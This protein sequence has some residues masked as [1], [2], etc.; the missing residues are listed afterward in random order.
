MPRNRSSVL[1]LRV[2]LFSNEVNE[3]PLAGWPSLKLD[4][5]FR[6]CWLFHERVAILLRVRF[7]QWRKPCIGMNLPRSSDV[8]K[9]SEDG[10]ISFLGL[11]RLAI[12]SIQP[13]PLRVGCL[14]WDH[15]R[16]DEVCE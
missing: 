6:V 5:L 12:P 10:P 13:L 11:R 3:H 1:R 14:V 4:T 16:I 9:P 2:Q 15:R 8:A 7:H